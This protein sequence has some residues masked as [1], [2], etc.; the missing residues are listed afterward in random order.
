M[1]STTRSLGFCDELCYQLH[2]TTETPADANELALYIKSQTTDL[3][4][5]V[6]VLYGGSVNSSDILS[7]LQ[8]PQIDGALIGGASL[9]VAEVKLIK[10]LVT[11]A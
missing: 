6:K 1:Y 5:P 9:K 10:K 2:F 11:K 4:K 3:T 7:F 8:E